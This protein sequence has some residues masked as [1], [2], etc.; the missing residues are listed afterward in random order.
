MGDARKREFALGL[1]MLC[2]GLVYL[3]LTFNLPRK[4]I[5]DAAFVPYVLGFAMC[6]L[7]GLQ[8]VAGRRAPAAASAADDEEAGRIDY[9]TVLKTVGLIVAYVALLDTVGFPIMT[10]LY[11]YAQFSV[12]QPAGRKINHVAYGAIAVVASVLIYVTFRFGFD[13]MLPA[14]FLD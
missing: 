13:L 1:L 3:V 12:L 2:A 6:I 9:T 7:G 5:I 10:V 4:G 11:L 14:G 8:V